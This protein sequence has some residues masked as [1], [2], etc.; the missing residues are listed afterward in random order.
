MK[1]VREDG[2]EQKNMKNGRE[3]WRRMEE[4]EIGQRRMGKN[5]RG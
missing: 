4:D 3:G 5:G 2:E 1:K